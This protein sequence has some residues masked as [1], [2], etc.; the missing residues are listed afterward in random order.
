MMK[1]WRSWLLSFKTAKPELTLDEAT[2]V[3][4]RVYPRCC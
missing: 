4:L 3:A 2:E 1:K